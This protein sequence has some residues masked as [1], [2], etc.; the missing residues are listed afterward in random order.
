MSPALFAIAK[1]IPDLTRME[2][3]NCGVVVW[4]RGVC[5]SRFLGDD[6]RDSRVMASIAPVV[7]DTYRQWVEYWRL[8]MTKDVLRDK[9]GETVLR[10]SPNFLSALCDSS[11]D[12]FVL[13]P[14]GRL[15]E[16]VAPSKTHGVAVSLF[17]AVVASAEP[18]REQTTDTSEVLRKETNR[19]LDVSGVASVDGFRRSYDWLCPVGDT[20][21]HFHFHFAI[22]RTSPEAVLQKVNLHRQVTVNDAA[23]MFQAMQAKYV[24]KDRCGAIVYASDEDLREDAVYQAYKLMASFGVV[25]NVAD[26]SDAVSKLASLA[27]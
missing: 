6:V 27:A 21:Q 22:H 2:P 19:A 14:A 12:N 18:V 17:D 4:N 26:Q 9:A 16:T 7:R 24:K 20:M 8:Q 3:R 13:A 11:L 1:Y 10:D 15:S 5:A 25:I 23:F